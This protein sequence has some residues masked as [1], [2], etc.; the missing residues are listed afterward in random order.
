MAQGLSAAGRVGYVLFTDADI[1]WETKDTC[2]RWVAAAEATTG[3]W[4]SDE[5]CAKGTDWEAS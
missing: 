5:R 2:A 1:A 3:T 4:F